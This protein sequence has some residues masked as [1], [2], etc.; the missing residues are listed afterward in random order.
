MTEQSVSV[1]FKIW[2][3]PNSVQDSSGR[4]WHIR[5]LPEKVLREIAQEW[6]EELVKKSKR[7]K[8]DD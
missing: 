2:M 7:K 3:I 4:S 8:T 5:D 1:K 6:T